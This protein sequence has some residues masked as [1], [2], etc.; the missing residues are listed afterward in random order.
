[1]WRA[2]FLISVD[3]GSKKHDVELTN[4][5]GRRPL[6]LWAGLLLSVA[7][8][9]LTFAAFPPINADILVW[10][11]LIPLLGALW[12]G[13]RRGGRRGALCYAL[14]GWVYGLMYFGGSFW[15]INEVSTLGFIPLSMYLS[16]YPALWAV[17][18]G[19][20]FR[21]RYEP[22]PLPGGSF[23]ERLVRWKQWAGRDMALTVRISLTGA[24]L[25][26]CT[27]WLRGWVMTGFGW[28]GLGVALH[29]S[30]AFAQFAEYVGVTGLAFIPVFANACFWSVGRRLGRMMLSEGRRQAPL[31]FFGL[32]IVLMLMFV[33][34]SVQVARHAPNPQE[35]LP[36][37]AV[38]RNLSQAY[39][40]NRGNAVSIYAEMAQST[41]GAF[42][43]LMERMA[44]DP[45][46]R[47]G[48]TLPAWV[49]WPESS[50]PI[51]TY[52]SDTTGK[53]L[54]DGQQ[55]NQWFFGEPWEMNMGTIRKSLPVDFVLITGEDEKWTDEQFNP[56]AVYNVMAAYPVGFD[57]RLVYRKNHLVPFGEYIPLREWL[58]L[59]E[60]AFAFSAGGAMGA[61][62]S[63]GGVFEPL[64]LP[65]RP[66]LAQ[67]VQV[68]PSVCFEDTVGRL[69]RRFA[70]PAPQVIVNVTNDGWF[71]D[72]WANEQHWRN[73]AFRSIELR[74]SMIRAANTGV[75]VAIA[76]NGAPIAQLRAPDGSPFTEGYL[77]ARLPVRYEGLTVYALAGDWF[78][79]LCVLIVLALR[80][81]PA[82]QTIHPLLERKR[83]A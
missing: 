68:I 13:P 5:A 50:L 69:L 18:M 25:W 79:I 29:D 46:G 23:A 61:N 78:V 20:V 3:M 30:L 63:P 32:C 48:L 62:F 74:R 38:Q 75:T 24:A 6:P 83:Q 47:Q 43:D 42:D 55:Y 58:P 21:P 53:A 80:F 77:Y 44:A 8:G 7:G 72:S 65:V 33:W 2:F 11:G 16:L 70:R 49:I 45:Q 19:T 51:S 64:E 39:K 4:A 57:S 26:V 60:D 76:P 59:L 28:N 40:W 35:G 56:S 1:M 22:D 36:V 31:D 71:N 67:T 41:R 54:G 73:A 9:L 37:V 14:Y 12:S 17:L 27:E 10:I 15:W 34:G 82:R 66:G 52:F 81:M